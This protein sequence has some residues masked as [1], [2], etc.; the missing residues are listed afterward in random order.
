LERKTAAVELASGLQ[1]KEVSKSSILGFFPQLL[2]PTL[3]A[4][5]SPS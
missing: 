3:W 4:Q 1:A 5:G 2:C